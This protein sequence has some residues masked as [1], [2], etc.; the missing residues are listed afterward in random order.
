MVR[1]LFLSS[2]EV[3]RLQFRLLLVTPNTGRFIYQLEMFIIMYGVPIEMD[4]FS[5]V[6]WQFLKV[7]KKSCIAYYFHL[8][9][10]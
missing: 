8:L 2:L 9:L 3:I 6:F 4:L 1:C 10:Y 7:F 5:L